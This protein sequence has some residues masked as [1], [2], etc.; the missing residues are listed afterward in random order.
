M[1]LLLIVLYANSE[2]FSE[3]SFYLII[4]E[5]GRLIEEVYGT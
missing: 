4:S 2:M 5:T 3:Y 1:R